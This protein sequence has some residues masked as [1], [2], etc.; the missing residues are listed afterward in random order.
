MTDASFP[1]VQLTRDGAVA[2]VTMN[3]PDKRNAMGEELLE[4]LC[5]VMQQL[6]R[7][8]S[9]RAVVVTGAGTVFSSGADRSAIA[10]LV[11]EERTRVFAPIGTR[12]SL[13]MWK[14]MDE[15][16]AMPK[17]VIAAVNGAAAGG[18]M[19]LAL[20]CDFRVVAENSLWWLPE[21]ELGFPL[22]ANSMNMLQDHFG[23]S[24]AKEIGMAARRLSAQ[25]LDRMGVTAAITTASDTL[26]E[27]LG[28]ARRIA[29]FEPSAVA[30]VK[31][32]AHERP[33]HALATRC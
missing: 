22:S 9:V 11:G 17:A 33:S 15:V 28:L 18:G 13:L 6:S 7:D 32:R 5:Q 19:M 14:V 24:K 21:I 29:A 12:L 2:I 23:S 3:R 1:F 30:A 25:D 8:E 4:S 26:A 31:R 20:A 27:A 16:I 10:G